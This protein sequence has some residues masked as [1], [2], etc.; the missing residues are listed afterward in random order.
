MEYKTFPFEIKEVEDAG[1][2]TGYASTF[3]G[4]PDLQGDIVE[5]GAFSGTLKETNGVY[6]ILWQHDYKQVVGFG[7]EAVQDFKGLLVKGE[8]TMAHPEGQKTY[9]TLQ[10]AQKVGHRMGLSIGFTLDK[11][12][13]WAMDGTFRRLRKIALH[14]YS[15]VTFPAQPKARVNTV[16]SV[17]EMTEREFEDT[18]RELGFSKKDTLCITAK[19]F[20]QLLKERREAGSD[21]DEI[22]IPAEVDQFLAKLQNDINESAAN[23]WLASMTGK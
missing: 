8:L 11:K 10:H 13:A 5:A 9:A 1:V 4:P 18:L 19:G 22:E 21:S 3:G 12:D 6:P 7:V 23:L 20:K 16:K 2:F 15:V 17:E 14:E